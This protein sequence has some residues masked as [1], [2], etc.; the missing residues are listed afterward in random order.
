MYVTKKHYCWTLRRGYLALFIGLLLNC[1]CS[2]QSVN[3]NSGK[4]FWFGYTETED[5][6][7]ASYVVYINSLKTT[8]GTLTIPGYAYTVNFTATPTTTVRLVLP[9]AD[10][11]VTTFTG[12]V[13]QAVHVVADSN[14]SVFAS[15]EYSERSDNSC[16]LP[17]TSLGN[18]YYIMDFSLCQSFSE[19]LI[20]A[21]DCKDSVEIT[22]SQNITVGGPHPAYVPYTEVLQPGQEL[23]VQAN[24]DL[25]GSRIRSLN[26]SETGVIAAAN[27]NCMYCS[28]T[29]NPFY[30]E[31]FPTS[32][33]GENFVFLPTAQAQ[34]QCRVLSET[35]GTVVT[36]HTNSGNNVQTL[37][38]GQYYDTTV[39][40]S[41]P[42]YISA[43]NPISVGRFLRTG[44]CN[45][46]YV[47]NP[48]GKGDPSEVIV[49]A[50]EQMYLDTIAFYVSR[51]PD[52]DSTYIQIV[53]R[54]SDKNSVFLDNVNIGAFFSTLIPNPTYSYC[55]LTILPGAHNL[56]TTG[57]GFVAYTCGLGYEDAMAADAGVY[58]DQLLINVTATPPSSCS[59]ADGSATAN[60][61]GISPFVYLWSNGQ[62]TQTATG[63]SAGIYTVTVSDSE[64]V[65][66]KAS[67]TII[68]SGKTGYT[69]TVTDTNPSCKSVFGKST[70]YPVGGTSPYT[71]NWNNGETTQTAT[72]LS[73]GSYTCT[74]TDNSGCVYFVTTKIQNYIPPGIGVAPY[75]D[76]VCG[77]SSQ[78]LHAYGLNTGIY[79]WAPNSGLSCYTCPNPTATPTATTTYTITGSDSNGCSA[80]AAVTIV[81]LGTPN[82]VITGKD[83]I[84]S[85]SSDTL[86]ASGGVTYLWSNG[87]TTDTIIGS[88]LTDRTFTL[89]AYN[90]YCPPHDTTFTI[91]VITTITAAISKSKDSVCLGDS[92]QLTAS[93]SGKYKWSN[94]KTSSSIWVKPPATTTYTLYASLGNCADSATATVRIIPL[95]TASFSAS[96]DSI[97]PNDTVVLTAIGAGG[98]VSYKW[99][100]GATT[101]AIKVSDTAST[102]YSVTVYGVCDSV[103]NAITVT[104]VPLPKPVITGTPWKC[105][106]NTDTLFVSGGSKYKWSNGSTSTSYITGPINADSSITV[107]SVNSLGCSKDTTFIISLR[108]ATAIISPPAVTC[109]GSEIRLQVSPTGVGP[110]TYLWTPG[111]ATT[112]TMTVNPTSTTIYTVT[113]F[114]GCLTTKVT[115]VIPDF[116]TLTGCCDKTILLGDDTIIYAVGKTTTPYLWQPSVVCLDPPLC[117]SVKVSPTVTTTY[118]IT[119]TDSL[120]CQIEKVVTIT[121]EAPCFDLRVPN[122]FTPNYPG[123]NGL[124]NVF[125]IKTENMTAWSIVIYD[126]WGKEMFKSSSPN[127]YWAGLTEGGAQASDGVY[128]YIISGTC[129]NK[130][131]K[132][133]GFLQLIR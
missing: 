120:G 45:N 123:P 102:T 119:M 70:V 114:N 71:Y 7:S 122:V 14:I 121:V 86:I 17:V 36:F 16:I 51:A 127:V 68:I 132:Q 115:T 59:A 32:N 103:K 6:T 22:P 125:Y 12:P 94:G 43:T 63:L 38:A 85:G 15:I 3:T 128:Y 55:S 92:V 18:D 81:I 97:C 34:D 44:S 49:D 118:T 101:S 83:S 78:P 28:G 109:S 1:V 60:V 47:T 33:W 61:T 13:N 87:A 116:P 79:N 58:L 56:T 88:P 106:G 98:K 100:N 112:D 4:D 10:V 54:T 57:Q 39:N 23:L 82:P 89:T 95:T 131:Y 74:V 41:A 77:V 53:T 90:G 133:Q 40:Y 62:T 30:E 9:S 124:N 130:T 27:W 111:G 21:Q 50:N 93:G 117:D 129:N 104:V 75:N 66:H 25:T 91:H 76:S 11:M 29:A 107:T 65:P 42:V 2:A 96:K 46:Y 113:V 8:N 69:A 99:S 26:H 37:N 24:G 35:N 110:F 31:L 67:A 80:S 108:T 19:F 84:C 73:A 48:T 126:R 20:V 52:I 5:L 105:A 64:C 72:G